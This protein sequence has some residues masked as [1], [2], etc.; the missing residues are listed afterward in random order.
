ML[1]TYLDLIQEQRINNPL[2]KKDYRL[3]NLPKQNNDF[4]LSINELNKYPNAFISNIIKREYPLYKN[5]ND[6]F[7]YEFVDIGVGYNTTLKDWKYFYIPFNSFN[8]IEQR[9]PSF[10]FY[11]VELNDTVN[12]QY[13][14]FNV[15]YINNNL[16]IDYIINS[17]NEPHPLLVHFLFT[18]GCTILKNGSILY[19]YKDSKSYTDDSSI[20]YLSNLS[21]LNIYLES[22]YLEEDQF[23]VDPNLKNMLYLPPSKSNLYNKDLDLGYT[24]NSTNIKFSSH[25]KWYE[26]YIYINGFISNQIILPHPPTN[27][28]LNFVNGFL[29]NKNIGLNLPQPINNQYLSI[30]QISNNKNIYIKL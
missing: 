17:K 11:D 14:N 6:I 12:T 16:N 10:K 8:V 28:N 25:K 30:N 5:T 7:Y 15:M 26:Y 4:N 21:P 13:L 27:K 22:T 18:G 9:L 29:Y 2:Y 23:F 20:S 24:G 19:E 1:S 3:I